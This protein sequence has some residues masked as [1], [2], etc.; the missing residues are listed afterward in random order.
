MQVGAYVYMTAAHTVLDASNHVVKGFVVKPAYHIPGATTPIPVD[1]FVDP[2]YTYD[3][4][5]VRGHDLAYLHASKPHVMAGNVYANPFLIVTSSDTGIGSPGTCSSGFK[6]SDP[7]WINGDSSWYNPTGADHLNGC[8]SSG[9]ARAIVHYPNTVGGG[10]ANNNTSDP[11]P[12]ISEGVGLFGGSFFGHYYELHFSSADSRPVIGMTNAFVSAGSSGAPL[13]ATAYGDTQGHA[14]LLGVVTVQSGNDGYAVGDFDYNHASMWSELNWQP[15]SQISI[16][17]PTEGASY[18]SSAVPNLIASAGSQTSQLQW[19]SDIDGVLGTGGNVAVAGRLSPGAQTITASIGSSASTKIPSLTAATILKTL[20]I[21]VTGAYPAPAFTMTPTTVL[22]PATATT[23]TYTYTWSAPGYPSLDV[24][25]QLNNGTPAAP[26]NVAASGSAS[27]QIA[28]G[29]TGRITFYPHGNTTTV[30]GTLTVRGVAAPLP[31]FAAN[32][33]HIVTNGATGNTTLTWNAPGYTAIDWCSRTNT[34][35]WHCD[36]VTTPPV[37]SSVI[38]V[39]VGTTYGGRIYP[40]GSVNQGGTYQLL[41]E[42]TVDAVG[43]GTPTFTANPAHVIIPA[44]STTGNT[45]ITWSATTYSGLD[46]C[47]NTNSGAWAFVISSAPSGKSTLPVTVGNT[48]G[49]RFYPAGASG[50]CTAVNRIGELTI[51][52]TH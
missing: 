33:V 48:Y 34:Q 45:V 38:A 15:T 52:A 44:G 37:G 47:S 39:P 12:Y 7:F 26:F 49:L 18:D 1:I 43:S 21:T 32:P 19:K 22:I 36:G 17:S 3:P 35:A 8:F 46:W 11:H 2:A 20:H 24:V 5:H 23:G 30:L 50:S 13:F 4:N 14:L 10:P 42:V 28:I 9:P 31:V 29:S 25:G 41:G 40:H 6:P 51:T 27:G 16:T